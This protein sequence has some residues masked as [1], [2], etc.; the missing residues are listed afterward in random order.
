A[1]AS[2]ADSIDGAN[3][4]EGGSTDARNDRPDGCTLNAC[5]GCTALT[6]QPGDAC[7]QCGKYACDPSKE[8]VSCRDPGDARVKQVAA[9]LTRTCVLMT[10]GGVRCWGSNSAGELGDGSNNPR[11]GPQLTDVL[12]G[13]RAITAGYQ[14]T[15]ALMESG[16]VRCWGSNYGG[17][18][19][20]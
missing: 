1:D 4:P 11:T 19:G 20:D 2:E 9:G 10:S 18:L 7:G 3:A 8:S 5:G 13:V 6:A 15:C 17:K 14:H 12:T 16:S